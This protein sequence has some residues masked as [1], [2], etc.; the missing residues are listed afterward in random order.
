M[1]IPIII[2]EKVVKPSY[3]YNEDSFTRKMASFSWIEA[4][5]SSTVNFSPVLVRAP[6]RNGEFRL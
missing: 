3:V 2:P 1:E 6:K 5:A 4:Q